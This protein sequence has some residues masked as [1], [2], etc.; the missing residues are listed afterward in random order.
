M[1]QL[2]IFR[3]AIVS[4]LVLCASNAP[5]RAA[6][7]YV[8]SCNV[9]FEGDSTLHGFTGDITNV[10]VVV[11]CETNAAGVAV[12]NS[13]IEIRPKQ[14]ST[15]HAKRDANMYQ[16]FQSDRYPHLVVAVTNAPLRGAQLVPSS[17]TNEPGSLPI[18]LTF[19][20]ITKDATAKTMNPRA[21]SD[22]WEFDLQTDVSLKAFK[23]AP[24]SVMF[25]AISVADRVVVKAH[26]AVQRE[27]SKH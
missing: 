11:Y 13:R 16:M 19:C 5:I 18:V 22:G 27:T 21:L 1:K 12:L 25:G 24:P 6:E 4:G 20:G 8:G 2:S 14:L 17:I 7:Q 10:P 3:A 15:H 23:L 26:V 9:L